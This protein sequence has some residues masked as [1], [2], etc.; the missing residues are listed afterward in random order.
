M[1]DEDTRDGHLVMQTTEPAAQFFAHLGIE[2]T[3]RFIEQHLWL[4]GKGMGQGNALTL[5]ARE[6]GRVAV[7]QPIELH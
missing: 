7:R 3:E 5:A 6:L 2:G 4:Y 1:C